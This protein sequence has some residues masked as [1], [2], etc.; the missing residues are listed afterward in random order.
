MIVLAE[1][2]TS[3]V[4]LLRGDEARWAAVVARDAAADGQFY[5]SVRTTGVYCRPSC[6]ARPAL[7]KN[8]GFHFS[9]AEAERAG[10]RACKRCKPNGTMI[11]CTPAD[12]DTT[13]RFA[14]GRCSLGSILV[15]T[16]GKGICAIL[17]GDDSAG[18]LDDLYGRFPRLAIS[19]GGMELEQ[20]MAKVISFVEAPK[21]GLDWPLDVKGTVFQRRVWQ[22]LSD[23]P[24]GATLS[25]ADVAKRIG[26]PKAV[27][28]VAQ[29]CAGNAIAVAVPCHRV[30]RSDGALAG[31]RWG[32]ARKAALLA[33]EVL[34]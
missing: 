21:A 28:A 33:R 2:P 22:A 7:R 13:I 9:C 15:A 1:K 10:F 19:A 30:V 12:S 3:H 6:K 16:T 26:S 25:Y 34:R 20:L 31:Y 5:Y 27:R 23:I 11:A 32:V 17:L 29:A 8:V 4:S 24:P 18:V 14:I